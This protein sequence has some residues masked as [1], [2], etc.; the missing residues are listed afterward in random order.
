MELGFEPRGRAHTLILCW[1]FQWWWSSRTPLNPQTLPEWAYPAPWFHTCIPRHPQIYCSSPQL[2][3]ISSS[4]RPAACWVHS[5]QTH[6]LWPALPTCF[7]LCILHLEK[8]PPGT[9]SPTLEMMMSPSLPPTPLPPTSNN[10]QVNRFNYFLS[11]TL[12]QILIISYHNWEP[13]HTAARVSSQNHS[14]S[15]QGSTEYTQWLLIP[16]G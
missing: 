6:H 8:T 10:Q 12:V 9:R 16:L 3:L 14:C 5:K 7:I 15:S 1:S 4:T 11:S 2:S 13:L